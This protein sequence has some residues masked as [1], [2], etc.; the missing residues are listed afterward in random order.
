M[1]AL[2]RGLPVE[3]RTIE[4]VIAGSLGRRRFHTSLFT[5]FGAVSL[6]LTVIGVY[7][8]M[9]YSVA[10][11][12]R[13]MGIRMALG[14]RR[15][16]VLRHVVGQGAALTLTGLALGLAAAWSLSRLMSTLV[17]GVAPRD[18]ATFAAVALLLAGVGLAASYLPARRASRVDPA[19]ALHGE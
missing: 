13:D 15:G 8:V 9:A 18:A 10:Q 2:D 11:R 3:V 16:D 4:Q 1:W 12:T 14:A 7:G 19:V 5:A 17:F 6:L